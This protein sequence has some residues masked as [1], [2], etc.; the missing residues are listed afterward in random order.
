MSQTDM[1]TTCENESKIME[2][3]IVSDAGLWCTDV[4]HL[5]HPGLEKLSLS[6]G[7]T[8]AG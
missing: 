3:N 5:P 4:E 8:G 2:K 6:S 7:Y 1:K